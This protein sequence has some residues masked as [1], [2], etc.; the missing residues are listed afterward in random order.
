M[1]FVSEFYDFS[2]VLIILIVITYSYDLNVFIKTECG[3]GLQFAKW[4]IQFEYIEC[5][6][7]YH[8]CDKVF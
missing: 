7:K 8:G 2:N 1:Q 5:G 3:H 4:V 6:S